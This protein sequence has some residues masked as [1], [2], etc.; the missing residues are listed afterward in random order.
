MKQFRF[1]L[2]CLLLSLVLILSLAGCRQE[3]ADPTNGP[4]PTT[5]PTQPTDPAKPTQPGSGP[6]V[7]DAYVKAAQDLDSVNMISSK[8][9]LKTTM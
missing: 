7:M 5:A 6:A 1:S 9:S 8:I 2:L 4:T 3:P